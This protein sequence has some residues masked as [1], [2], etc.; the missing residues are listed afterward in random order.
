[1]LA[2]AV[3]HPDCPRVL[4]LEDHDDQRALLVAYFAARG[5]RVDAAPDLRTARTILEHGN[6]HDLFVF[7]FNLPDGESSA[8]WQD[9][10]VVPDRLLVISAAHHLP[11]LPPGAR[12]LAKPVSVDS[13]HEEVAHFLGSEWSRTDVPI[14]HSS[15]SGMITPPRP[16][17]K[18]AQRFV[19]YLSGASPLSTKAR[20]RLEQLLGHTLAHDPAIRVVDI[21]TEVG[22]DEAVENRVVFTPALCRITPAPQIWIVG[23]FE[24]DSLMEAILGTTKTRK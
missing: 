11:P 23:D 2:Y 19:L 12:K 14:T 16:G 4:I 21:E 22:M 20:H 10:L 6:E 9:P 24:D 18:A 15:A 1:M 8:L 3:L 13:L 7:D 17:E 5:C